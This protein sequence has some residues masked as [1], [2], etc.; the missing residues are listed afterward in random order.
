MSFDS[1][2][3][4]AISGKLKEFNAS[5]EEVSEVLYADIL[6]SSQ[7]GITRLLYKDFNFILVLRI[8]S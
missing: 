7:A 5:L 8:F 4:N 3:I 2:N 1:A 6:N